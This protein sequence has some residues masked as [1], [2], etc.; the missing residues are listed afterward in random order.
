MR[1]GK[2]LY[3]EH[4]I[5]LHVRDSW[6]TSVQSDK[7]DWATICRSKSRKHLRWLDW[8]G[9]DDNAKSEA[10]RVTGMINQY[11]SETQMIRNTDKKCKDTC[12]QV[13]PASKTA[14]S[15][16]GDWLVFTNL[17][18]RIPFREHG[19]HL[20]C[21]PDYVIHLS[22]QSECCLLLVVCT[23]SHD[24]RSGLKSGMF[25]R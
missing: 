2:I 12:P 19:K 22:C 7:K 8:I 14:A 1:R 15:P 10:R 25:I 17:I 23:C 21:G 11:C 6:F 4:L 24:H 16:V 9:F 18:F 5:Y 13:P 20:F 3:V